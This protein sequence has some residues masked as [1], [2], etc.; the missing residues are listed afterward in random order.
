MKL[1]FHFNTA[2]FESKDFHFIRHNIL[3][4]PRPRVLALSVLF[5]CLILQIKF[6]DFYFIFGWIF[7][8]FY[9]FCFLVRNY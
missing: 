2:A 9:I 1:R 8:I 7:L 4:E 5:L 3:L 6:I